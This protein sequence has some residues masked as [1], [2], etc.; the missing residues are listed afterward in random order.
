MNT[1]NPHDYF[2]RKADV[3]NLKNAI[4]DKQAEIENLR[5]RISE[6]QTHVNDINNKLAVEEREMSRPG[7]LS[8][9]T[10]SSEQFNEHKRAVTEMEAEV[11]VLTEA[12]STRNRDLTMLQNDF[13]NKNRQLN[14]IRAKTADAIADQVAQ[15]IVELAGDPI[16]NLIHAMVASAGK[17]P[18]EELF[19]NKLGIRILDALCQD[20]AQGRRNTSAWLP[21]LPEANRHVEGQLHQLHLAE[22]AE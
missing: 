3:S 22:Q 8:K 13:G 19:L 15:Q 12:I 4:A 6:T 9:V 17:H 11:T 2:K 21:N 16:K 1:I 20:H 7:A 14:N 5:R 10:L 18:D